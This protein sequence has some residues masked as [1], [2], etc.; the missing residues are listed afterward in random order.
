MNITVGVIGCGYISSFHFPALEKAGVRVKWVCDISRQ[1]AEKYI[2]STGAEYTDDYRRILADPEVNLV[3]V[4]TMTHLHKQVCLDAIAAGKN[5]ICEKTLTNTADDSLEV[6]QAAKKKGVIFYTGFMKRYIPAVAKAKE[7]MPKI[8]KVVCTHVRTYQPYGK[9]SK[10]LWFNNPKDGFMHTPP[11]GMSGI[12]EKLGGG[13]LPTGG[14]HIL[15]LV[16]FF[17]GRPTSLYA[18]VN[19]PEGRDYDLHVAALLHTA[20]GPVFFDNMIHPL[21]G[22]GFH[23]DGWD[24]TVEI[25][26]L[27]GKL[28]IYSAFWDKVLWKPTILKHFDN[29]SNQYH[30][31]CFP[32]SSPFIPEIAAYCQ[33]IAEGKQGNPPIT[34]GYDVDELIAHIY[35]SSELGKPLD[36][37]W[38]V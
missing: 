2:K 33:N 7:L 8:G 28:E 6:I 31:Y 21:E 20:N 32:A 5:V 19:F 15:D 16:G 26:G 14:S 37:N 23:R 12:R 38:R 22:I 9:G 10:D 30:E 36:I 1:A 3:E 25:T 11:G 17:H 35:K 29:E 24:E 27:D 34:A 13:I 4:L 18:T